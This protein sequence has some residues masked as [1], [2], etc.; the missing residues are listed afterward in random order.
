[1][2]AETIIAASGSTPSTGADPGTARA[3]ELNTG[4]SGT[5]DLSASGL[6]F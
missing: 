5:G 6:D 4:L 1:M 3:R 2:L